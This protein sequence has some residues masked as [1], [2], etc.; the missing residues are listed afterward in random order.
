[1]KYGGMTALIT[2][3]SSGLGEAFARQLGALGADLVLVARSE[4]K[5]QRLA[6]TLRA[7]CGVHVRVVVADLGSAVAVDGLIAEVKGGGVGIDLLVNNAG[8]GVF[9][10]FLDST[11]ESEQQQVDV[12]VRAV[13]SLTRAFV[14]GMVAAGRGGVITIGSTAGFQPLAGAAVYAAS[15]AF[16]L[17]FSEALSLELDKTGVTVTAACPGPVATE[18][19]SD[20]NPEQKAGE[21]DQAGPVVAEILRGFERGKRVVYPGKVSN[22][23]S[24]LGARLMPRNVILRM[25]ARTTKRLN[26]KQR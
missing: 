9:E 12:N 24:T 2:G 26:Q 6:E 4:E 1:M 11:V 18:F 17:L 15:K 7:T 10:D 14:P 8:I 23:F 5:L 22:W 21:M 3:A 20:K 13:V 19:F 25:A 16:V